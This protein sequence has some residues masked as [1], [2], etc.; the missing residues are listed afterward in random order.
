MLAEIVKANEASGSFVAGWSTYS[1]GLLSGL[2]YEFV[3]YPARG[4][5][6]FG[7]NSLALL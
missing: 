2:A 5:L 3:E 6:A 7:N 4:R 1:A